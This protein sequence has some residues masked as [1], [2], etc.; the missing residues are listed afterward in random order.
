[1]S[2]NC[3][4]AGLTKVPVSPASLSVSTWSLQLLG[5]VVFVTYH[6]R[7]GYPLSTYLDFAALSVQSINNARSENTASANQVT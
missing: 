2:A 6:V 7:S 1:M 4:I 5:F 3:A